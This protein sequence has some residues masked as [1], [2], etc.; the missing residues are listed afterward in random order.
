MKV[1]LLSLLFTVVS[2][3][4]Q[5]MPVVLVL[6]NHGEMGDTG[7]P[8][9]FY[10]SEAAHPYAEITKAGYTV[11]IASPK[12]GFA[13]VDPK[14]LDMKDVENAAFWEKFGGEKDGRKGIVKTVALAEIKSGEVAG[15]F[16]AG[17]H[18]TMWDL[19][20][21]VAVQSFTTEV[22]SKGGAVGAVCHGPAALV[23]V[24]D[25]D[26]KPIVQGKKVAVFTNEEEEAVKLTDVVPF[27]LQD[28]MEKAG[29]KV[30]PGE[31]F[32]ENA[33]RDGKLVTGQNPASAK[34]AGQLMIQAIEDA[35]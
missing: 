12:G 4:A 32:A 16:Y 1:I 5:M 26:G 22:Y 34:K 13:P 8:T 3:A 21:S 15:V 9:G 33:V 30:L 27:L 28:E 35:D 17:G 31:K 7:K 20:D 29:A 18:G 10:L 11:I 24:K 23:N 2:Y 14:S 19:P 6:T 25:A